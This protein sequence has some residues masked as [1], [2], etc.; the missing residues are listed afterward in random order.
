MALGFFTDDNSGD[1]YESIQRK[2]KL[3]DALLA[4]SQDGAPIQ[5]W[6]QGGAKLIQALAGSLQ[7]RSLDTKERESSKAF[8]ETLM[9]ALGGQS[10]GSMPSAAPSPMPTGGGLLPAMASGGNIPKMVMPDPV[11]GNLDATQKALLN[12]I[13]APESAGAYNRLAL[14]RRLAAINS[15]RQLGIVWG[16]VSLRLKIRIN[17]RLLLQ[18]RT[19]RPALAAT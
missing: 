11:Y 10:G 6:T 3:A 15:R 19:T 2:R 5:S 12:A 17:A 14:R 18:I 9:R 7:N 8:N 4:Q 13:A 1:S 16:A